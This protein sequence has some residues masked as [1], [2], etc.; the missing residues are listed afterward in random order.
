MKAT[1]RLGRFKKPAPILQVVLPP[2]RRAERYLD[3]E[4][5]DSTAPL[6]FLPPPLPR[7]C[8]WVKRV[9]EELMVG[10]V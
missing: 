1:P 4:D 3:P 6:L 9:P 7:E 10:A 2:A 5:K 8:P